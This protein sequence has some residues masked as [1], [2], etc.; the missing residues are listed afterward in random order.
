[1]K[2]SYNWLSSYLKT[3]LPVSV[4]VETL[5]SIGLEVES[6][7]YKEN[8][9]GGLEGIYVGEV[10]SCE[11]H[12]EAD[13]LSLTSVSLGEL[14]EFPIVCG[15]P[16]VRAGQ[17]VLVATV[18]ATLYPQSG[19][20][21]TIKKSKIRGAASEGMI[22]AEDELQLGS[23][24]DGIIV[25]DS[26]AVAG[27]KAA[28][29]LN[30]LGGYKGKKIET[31]LLIEIGLT[32]NR[33]DATSH[34][35]V[36]FDLHAALSLIHPGKSELIRPVIHSFEQSNQKLA[37]QIQVEDDLLC[38]RY[39]GVCL[40]GVKIQ[41]SPEWL[42]NRLIAIGLQPINNVVDLSNF[43]LHECGQPL[44]C[45]DYDKIKEKKIIV[46]LAE[47][48]K[49]FKSLDG[50]DRMLKGFE[51]CIMDAQR[52]PM[53]LAGVYGGF[54]SGVSAETQN[55]FI[56]SA[57][58][59]AK[60]IRKT[61]M[62]HLLRTDAASCFE[63][64][65]DPNLTVFA[66]ERFVSLLQE[67]CPAQLASD[68]FDVYPNP[69]PQVNLEIRLDRVRSVTGYP[70]SNEDILQVLRL[71]DMD[72]QFVSDAVCQVKIPT[73]KTDVLREIDVIEE[74]LRIYGFNRFVTS[75]EI[76]FNQNQL[77][78]VSSHKV[79]SKTAEWLSAMGSMECMNLSLS[80]SIYYTKDGSSSDALV[81]INNTS[82]QN[83]DI[84][85]PD[86]LFGMLETLIH[87]QNR[88]QSDLSLF[89]FGKSYHKI[90]DNQFKE[91][92]HLCLIKTGLQ[93]QESWIEK[94][95]KSVEYYHLKREIVSLFEKWG[96]EIESSQFKKETIENDPLWA[97]GLSYQR[98]RDVI[99]KLG[100]IHPSVCFDM[101]IKTAVFF[102][103]IQ[104]ATV[105][106]IISKKK[107][108]YQPLPKFPMVRRDLALVLEKSITFE[109]ISQIAHKVLKNN[110]LQLN[111]FDVYENEEQLGPN[112]KSCA[113][114]FQVQ[115]PQKTLKDQDID[116]WMQELMHK[117]EK[118]LG[119]I[120]RK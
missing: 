51:L 45:F 97:Y 42:K 54:D 46:G 113:I 80:K 65:S 47:K 32:P 53:C 116:Q 26:Q 24:H 16:N 34:W 63:K 69:I 68:W 114:S 3:D 50:Q 25:L 61:S 82:N 71:L 7:E 9:K 12:P 21:L 119:A 27:Q 75:T 99:L 98:G 19:E 20:A 95:P 5:T 102:A 11:K 35:G 29:Y 88:Q 41:E 109:S 103:D 6:T 78:K 37:L 77:K 48:G 33:S 79:K 22:C 62:S 8:I 115:D 70:I 104:W 89:E 43:I 14:G 108:I 93:H 110:L 1:M 105:L 107:T 96:I 44:H 120:I 56:E 40:T 49:I 90:D 91:I 38:P 28:D 36:A 66:L 100:R 86:L 23:S 39:S 67:I 59:N 92:E 84:M 118:E 72:P 74:I 87:N 55:L 83:L 64:G 13:R 10:L 18:G 2:L 15:A 57:H 60:S 52:E 76:K 112:K 106:Q 58:F 17:K 94:N 81:Y 117:Y 73:N 31:D 85:R 30:S 111:L 101:G 4:L